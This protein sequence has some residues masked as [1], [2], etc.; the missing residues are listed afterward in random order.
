M[1]A[2]VVSESLCSDLRNEAAEKASTSELAEQYGFSVGTIRYHI[3]GDCKHDIELSALSPESPEIPKSECDQIRSRFAAG[4]DIDDLVEDFDH[5]WK[6][7]VRH[8]SGECSHEDDELVVDRNE[9]L[10]RHPITAEA[11]AS[12]REVF[13]SN[14]DS[15]LLTL[16]QSVP[17]A[18]HTVVTHIN[19]KCDHEVELESREIQKRR[20][21]TAERCQQLREAYRSNTDL[22]LTELSPLAEEFDIPEGSIQRHIRFRCSHDPESSILDEIDGWE[23]DIEDLEDDI[24]TTV[25]SPESDSA[26]EPTDSKI[27]YSAIASETGI[28]SPDSSEI[29][30][31]IGN[32]DPD[33][34]E[35]TTSRIVRNT[36][37][38]KELKEEY[39]YH[40]QVCGE[41]RH[42]APLE[43]YAEAHHIKPL[44][45]PHEGPDTKSNILILCPNHHAD[46]DH[47]LIYVDPETY[48]I[49]HATD[50]S[51]SGEVL[52][53][54]ECHEIKPEMIEYHNNEISKL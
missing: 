53:T 34:V 45:Q 47:G 29:V 3:Y 48:E 10:Q 28:S 38:A 30:A 4:T 54:K 26:I 35:T 39:Q 42:K 19:G 33:R 36:T 5:T 20:E 21:I 25:E 49:T 17:W 51:L 15:T 46:F 22:T 7:V 43:H 14:E 16:S 18:Y 50:E 24:G 2:E 11:C 13:H 40:C 32:P 9:I 52:Q 31:D 12:L 23:S 1:S 27:D 41:A 6:T 44:G 37:L 8:L